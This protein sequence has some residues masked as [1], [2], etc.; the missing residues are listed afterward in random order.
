MGL[1]QFAFSRFCTCVD[2]YPQRGR[3][4]ELGGDVCTI[5]TAHDQVPIFW[6]H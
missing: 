6:E 1:N 2:W 3:D 5:E 4:M